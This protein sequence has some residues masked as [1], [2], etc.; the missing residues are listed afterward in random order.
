MKINLNCNIASLQA[1][2][3]YFQ[4]GK[5]VE[6]G[7]EKL[8]SGLRITRANDDYGG[9]SI[10]SKMR[11][12]AAVLKKGVENINEGISVANIA[13]QAL[14]Q[15]TG[16]LT[17]QKELAEQSANGIYSDDQRLA[18]N[19][20]ANALVEE[21]NR[22]ID[23]T[24]YNGQKILAGEM[25]ELSIQ[26]GFGSSC[27]ATFCIGEELQIGNSVGEAEL[28]DTAVASKFSF[29][30]DFDGDGSD[31]I[32]H[33]GASDV[34]YQKF[35]SDEL[36]SS[37]TYNHGASGT[38]IDAVM[39]DLDENGSQDLL[40]LEDAAGHQN[41]VSVLNASSQHEINLSDAT[42][43]TGGTSPLGGS[44]DPQATLIAGVTCPPTKPLP[45]IL[46][47]ARSFASGRGV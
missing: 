29:V 24:S 35:I 40:F 38:K 37:T 1:R 17:R 41:L 16:I 8:S 21:Y 12:E 34:V 31:E 44:G 32:A 5:D 43:D 4:I 25:G 23:T 30:G 13:D 18:M 7:L 19:E 14:A 22:V 20:E 11:T 15:L 33:L 9:M 42:P 6:R 36:W 27:S 45:A 28:L 10:A 3:N 47:Y 26:G 2:R 39:E 46:G